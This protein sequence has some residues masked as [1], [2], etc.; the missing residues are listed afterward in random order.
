LD[1]G[2]HDL[3]RL[4]APDLVLVPSMGHA[5]TVSAHERRAKMLGR[6]A[7]TQ[8]VVAGQPPP[9][10]EA[11]LAGGALLPNGASTLREG[12]HAHIL[13]DTLAG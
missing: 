2:A 3:W 13:R 4:L 9:G 6:Y 10:G 8:V 1:D 7:G 11:W 5:A 12:D